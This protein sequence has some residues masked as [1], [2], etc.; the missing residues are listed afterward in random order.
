MKKNLSVFAMLAIVG[1]VAAVAV[2]GVPANQAPETITI[3]EAAAKKGPVEF[4]HKAHFAVT[5]CTTCHHTQEGLTADS[6][7]EV[8]KCSACH[9]HPESAETPDMSQMSLK[10]NPFHALCIDCH[11][12]EAKGPTK[13]N[14]CHAAK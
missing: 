4:P 12:K 6:T 14:D 7:M 13:C 8:E 10:K 9:L 11:K 5:A 2:A 1:L 3:N